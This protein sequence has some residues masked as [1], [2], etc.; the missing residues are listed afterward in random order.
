[1]GQNWVETETAGCDL[2]DVRLNRRLGAMLEALGERPGKSLPTAFQHWSNRYAY[3]HNDPVNRH[4]PRGNSDAA[5]VIGGGAAGVACV[6]AEPCGIIALGIGALAGIAIVGSSA[7][8]HMNEQSG[9]G[10]VMVAER[11]IGDLEPIDAPGRNAPRPELEELSD[12]D[13]IGAI[14]DPEDGQQIKVKGNRILDGNG[15]IKEALR[16]GLLG[17]DDFVPVEELPEDEDMAPWENDADDNEDEAD[18][19]RNK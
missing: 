15:R 18:D 13:L 2:G 8:D 7:I 9:A 5:A 6:L 12:E 19:E 1:M 10:Q 11:R 16:R 4:D 17:N 14:F 3:S